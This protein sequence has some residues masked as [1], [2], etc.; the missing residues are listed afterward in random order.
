MNKEITVARKISRAIREK[1][2]LS[3]YLDQLEDERDMEEKR[4][5][6]RT[7]T[8]FRWAYPEDNPELE[9]WGGEAELLGF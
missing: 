5:R 6:K 2:E 7:A 1:M 9:E 8:A 3:R 4:S